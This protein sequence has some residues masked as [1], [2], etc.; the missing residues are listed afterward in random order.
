GIGKSLLETYLQRPNHIVIGSVRDPTADYTTTLTSLPTAPGSRLI[1]TTIESTNFSDPATAISSLPDEIT[2]IDAVIANG[3]GGGSKGGIPLD[4]VAP[5]DITDVV[6]I[7]ILAPLALYQAT[8]T[9]L[10]KAKAPK[11][12][13]VSSISASIGGVPKFKTHLAAGYGIAKAWLNWLTVAIGSANDWIVAFAVYPGLV[14]TDLGNRS[15]K[16]LGLEQA[17]TTVE[18]SSGA[19]IRLIDNATK[20]T[21]GEKFFDAVR[22]TE[23]PW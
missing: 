21:A 9:L 3:G 22:G 6:N 13:S 20:E 12:V 15:A 4:V 23:L 8:R 11:W 1:L 17:P 19:I 10:Q 16:K 2:H 7:N 14:Q 18:E 5:G